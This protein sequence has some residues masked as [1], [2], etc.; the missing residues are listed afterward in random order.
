MA[1]PG[2]V[3]TLPLSANI[4]GDFKCDLEI[5]PTSRG[6][7]RDRVLSP[8]LLG[9]CATPAGIEFQ[10]MENLW[11]FSKVYPKLGHVNADGPRKGL[12]SKVWHDW[13]QEGAADTFAHRYPAGKG[14]IPAYSYWHHHCLSYVVARKTIYIPEYA[15]LAATEMRYVELQSEHQ[16]GANIIIRDFD[17]YSIWNTDTTLLDVFNSTRRAGHGFVLA[18]ML[19]HG[20]RFYRSLI[21]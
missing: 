20:T 9:P 4:P 3:L 1:R 15:R 6:P 10:N 18:A 16:K 14:A 17:A 7:Q 2:K 12:P 19:V 8:F 21:I 5:Y 13:H 11:Q